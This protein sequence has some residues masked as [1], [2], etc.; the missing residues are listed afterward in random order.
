MSEMSDWLETAIGNSVLRGVAL[1]I[2]A[3][4]YAALDS[5]TQNDAAG[6]TE[7]AGNGYARTAITFTTTAA[8]AGLFANNLCTFP[9]ATANW[10]TITGMSIW[11]TITAGNML[12]YTALDAAKYVG[13]NDVFQFP[14]G[15]L[16]V[17]IA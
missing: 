13:A 6:G 11:D 4:I 10:L 5:A 14:A 8:G 15:S 17:T 2:P 7:L 12:L 16:T 1:S 9:T 3:T